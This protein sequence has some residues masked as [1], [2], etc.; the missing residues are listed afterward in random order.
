VNQSSWYLESCP[1]IGG[2][3]NPS[4]TAF[5]AIERYDAPSMCLVPPGR[6]AWLPGY[7]RTVGRPGTEPWHL[8]GPQGTASRIQAVAIVPDAELLIV[9]H[10]NNITLSEHLEWWVAGAPAVKVLVDRRAT[11]RRSATGPVADER[12]HVRTRRIRQGRISPVGGYTVVRFTPK[13]SH[14]P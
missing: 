10:R 11:D 5:A 3:S 14:S 8:R 13:V 4:G 7:A 6:K 1:E 2:S 9:A 12:R